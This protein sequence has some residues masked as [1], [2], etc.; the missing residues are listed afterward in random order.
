MN[1]YYHSVAKR[2]RRP[3]E[4][5]RPIDIFP[6]RTSIDPVIQYYDADGNPCQF[7]EHYYIS[8]PV[9]FPFPVGYT[10]IGTFPFEVSQPEP[11]TVCP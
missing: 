9:G 11:E 10:V 6:K 7:S 4:L 2:P 5:I 3:G 1:I 8:A